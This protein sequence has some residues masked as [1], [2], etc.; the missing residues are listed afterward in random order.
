MGLDDTG[1]MGGWFVDDVR[2]YNCISRTI[3]GNAGAS[4]VT[5]SYTRRHSQDRHFPGKWQLLIEGPEQLVWNR[6]PN[7]SVLH[8]QS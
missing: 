6:D 3:S 7:P 1:F 2:V 8:I 5:L 4:G